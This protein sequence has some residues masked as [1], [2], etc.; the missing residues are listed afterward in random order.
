NAGKST[1]ADEAANAGKSTAADEAANAGKSTAADEAAEP[2]T[3]NASDKGESIPA[4]A[5][6]PTNTVSA[7]YCA[8]EK[9]DIPAKTLSGTRAYAP[10]SVTVHDAVSADADADAFSDAV[11]TNANA[12]SDA[13]PINAN[14]DAVSTSAITTAPSEKTDL[15][16]SGRVVLFVIV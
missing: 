11:S 1:A 5:P 14:A 16:R 7:W 8:V 3:T 15:P 12:L 9:T 13:I 10:A 4:N 6:K 2:G